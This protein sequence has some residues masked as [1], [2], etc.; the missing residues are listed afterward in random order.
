MRLLFESKTDLLNYITTMKENFIESNDMK[1]FLIDCKLALHSSAYGKRIEKRWIK[2][3]GYERV[4]HFNRGDYIDGEDYVEFKVSYESF[5]RYTFLHIRPWENVDR[6]DLFLV[7]EN[8]NY[9]VYEIPSEVILEFIENGMAEVCNG[10][11]EAAKIN[12]SK[13]YRFTL[14]VEQLNL[15]E[16]YL[17][18]GKP[19]QKLHSKFW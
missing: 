12:D 19:K 6:Y 17:T 7:D 2:E 3:M 10:T 11:K 16:P 5:S 8:F 9:N 13:E 18:V 14:T 15:I 4:L 1:E